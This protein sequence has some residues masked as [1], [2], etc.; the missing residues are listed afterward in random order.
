MGWNPPLYWGSTS[1]FH[2]RNLMVF[3]IG[4]LKIKQ[5]NE[6]I[7]LEGSIIMTWGFTIS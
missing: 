3:V 6:N 1:F 5:A 7:F 4:F 2:L